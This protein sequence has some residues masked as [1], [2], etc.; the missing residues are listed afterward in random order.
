MNLFSSILTDLQAVIA[1]GAA[2][3]RRLTVLLVA[4]WGR[5]ARM[6]SRLERLVALWRAGTLPAP[7]LRQVVRARAAGVVPQLRFPT[8]P[9]WLRHRLGHDV[10]AYASQLQHALGEAECVAF[11]AAVPE[12]GRILRPLLRMLTPDA[13]P[14]VIRLVRPKVVRVAAAGLIP[15]GVAVVM[16]DYEIL[17]G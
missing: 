6:R 10:S 7:R 9:G 2:R 11:L 4:V 15:A 16:P 8:I 14:D 5:V 1:A 3:D 17:E 12:A 13:V